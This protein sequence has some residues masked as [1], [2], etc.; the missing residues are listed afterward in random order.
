MA[1][2]VVRKFSPNITG[3]SELLKPNRVLY[4]A[5]PKRMQAKV[6]RDSQGSLPKIAS[7]AY[8][9]DKAMEL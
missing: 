7:H 4:R 9:D 5:G 1:W 6:R 8:L 3:L 2:L